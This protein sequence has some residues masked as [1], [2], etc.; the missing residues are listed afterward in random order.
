MRG[1]GGRRAGPHSAADGRPVHNGQAGRD[2]ALDQVLADELGTPFALDRGPLTRAVLVRL[3]PAD[4]VLMLSQHHIITDG[5]SVRVLVDELSELYTAA[6]RNVPARLA[7]LPIQYPDF[8]V[9]QRQRL[10][11]R[12]WRGT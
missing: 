6:L 3:A 8:A 2:A 4:H 1:P 10:P 5:W 11:A 12:T 9:W 7:E